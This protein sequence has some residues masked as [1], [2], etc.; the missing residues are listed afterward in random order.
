MSGIF[1]IRVLVKNC[2][3]AEDVNLQSVDFYEY[4]FYDE[5]LCPVFTVERYIKVTKELRTGIDISVYKGI[6]I[7]VYKPLSTRSASVSKM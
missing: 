5:A 6:D 1:Y 4:D 3:K 7:S 2:G